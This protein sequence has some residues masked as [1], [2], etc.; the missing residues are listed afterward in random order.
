MAVS[1]QSTIRILAFSS[2]GQRLGAGCGDNDI[3]LWKLSAEPPVTLAHPLVDLPDGA[4]L[5]GMRREKWAG[6]GIRA[7]VFDPDGRRLLS[8]GIDNTIRHWDIHEGTCPGVLVRHADSINHLSMNPNGWS[9]VTGGVDKT[10]RIWDSKSWQ[11]LTAPLPH[12]FSLG[13]LAFSPDGT[14]VATGTLAPDKIRIWDASAGRCEVEYGSWEEVFGLTFSPDGRVV[15]PGNQAS[16]FR[17]GRVRLD[18]V[19]QFKARFCTKGDFEFLA[20][21]DHGKYLTSQANCPDAPR[22]RC[23]GEVHGLE[24]PSVDQT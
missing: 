4:V 2:S 14:A 6:E 8:S 23:G 9:C 5:N 24:D 21:E 16:Q 19:R 18:Q 10:A 20:T 3:H 22:G 15:L 13:A 17:V 12:G 7:V 1:R 11:A